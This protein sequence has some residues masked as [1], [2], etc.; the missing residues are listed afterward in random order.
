M[1]IFFMSRKSETLFFGQAENPHEQSKIKVH[2]YEPDKEILLANRSKDEY[3][4][5]IELKNAK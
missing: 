5:M 1:F 3:Y 4:S 2:Q